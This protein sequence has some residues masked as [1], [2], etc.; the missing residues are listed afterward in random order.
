[1]KKKMFTCLL[2]GLVIM[3]QTAYA[4]TITQVNI[5]QWV[6]GDQYNGCIIT[7]NQINNQTL[8]QENINQTNIDTYVAGDNYSDCDITNN[9]SSGPW[10]DEID[11]NVQ[12]QSF[13][14]FKIGND[15]YGYI[16]LFD[17]YRNAVA[18]FPHFR[19][20]SN[21]ISYYGDDKGVEDYGTYMMAIGKFSNDNYNLV[22]YV[23]YS[24]FDSNP[25]CKLKLSGDITT[26]DNKQKVINKYGQPDKIDVT[27]VKEIY[28]YNF[29]V[30]K[31]PAKLCIYFVNNVVT[32]FTINVIE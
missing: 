30:N 22:N 7:N 11:T 10:T 3:G 12:N 26:G 5:G 18:R 25:N 31:Y 29:K 28:T 2:L 20:E 17:N 8:V 14:K 9:S 4:D 21:N 6:A 15:Q 1:M 19:Y 24:Q 13:N 32:D 16:S 27:E 23:S